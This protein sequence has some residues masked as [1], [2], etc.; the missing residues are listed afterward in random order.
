MNK[1]DALE[2]IEKVL[3]VRYKQIISFL[4]CDDLDTDTLEEIKRLH[5]FQKRMLSSFSFE[6][7][8]KIISHFHYLEHITDFD[9][10]S[11]ITRLFLEQY[12]LGSNQ[13]TEYFN[14]KENAAYHM[15]E[16][17]KKTYL[18]IFEDEELKQ[19]DP[20][21]HDYLEKE[22]YSYLI[23]IILTNSKI[24]E[25][26]INN[27][28]DILKCIIPKLDEDFRASSLQ[29]YKILIIERCNNKTETMNPNG[30]MEMLYIGYMFE[31]YLNDL[32]KEDIEYLS[33]FV[34]FQME[35]FTNS[36]LKLFSEKLSGFTR[37]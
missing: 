22:F 18:A 30:V 32:S 10:K 34:I 19:I 31:S 25:L 24:E 8:Q 11:R 7:V 17:L 5:G 20:E 33:N 21:F 15:I 1:I 2:L 37:K 4:I 26:I 29:A 35:S 6:E 12:I 27:D 36:Y 28:F 3:L 14:N 13:D 9:L 23:S 16:A